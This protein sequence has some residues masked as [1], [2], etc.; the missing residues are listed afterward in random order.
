MKKLGD[1][2]VFKDGL[3]QG[4]PISPLIFYFYVDNLLEDQSKMAYAYDLQIVPL[5]GSLTEAEWIMN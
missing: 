4:S 5:N 2:I 3:P 1:W